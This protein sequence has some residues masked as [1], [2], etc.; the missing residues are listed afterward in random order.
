MENSIKYLIPV[1]LFAGSPALAKQ[2]KNALA[3]YRPALRELL[4]EDVQ[5]ERFR[6]EDPEEKK[7]LDIPNPSLGERASLQKNEAQRSVAI[8]SLQR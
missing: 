4:L 7:W 3:P 2:K 6:L 8:G 1:M 5:V